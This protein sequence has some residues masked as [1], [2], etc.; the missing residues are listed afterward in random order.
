MGKDQ[1]LCDA[2]YKGSLEGVRK[3]LDAGANPNCTD[4]PKKYVS[5]IIIVN[6]SLINHLFAIFNVFLPHLE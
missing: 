3:A 2:A 4:T 1:D 6:I 5:F